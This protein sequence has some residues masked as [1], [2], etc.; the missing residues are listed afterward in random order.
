MKKGETKSREKIIQLILI[1]VII[2]VAI[3]AVILYL[4]NEYNFFSLDDNDNEEPLTYTDTI[5]YIS[6]NQAYD[7]LINSDEIDI[8]DVRG[9]KC[10]YRGGHIPTANWSL[11]PIDYYN[12][13]RDILVY[14]NYGVNGSEDNKESIEFCELLVGNVYGKIYCLEDGITDWREKDYPTV[15]GD[16]PGEWPSS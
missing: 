8:I 12:S 5:T 15:N 11:N 13:T 1:V 6:S 7:L 9:C 2:V 14:D 16:E 10:N 4:Q 3:A